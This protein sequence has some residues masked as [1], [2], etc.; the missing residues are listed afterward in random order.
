MRGGVAEK[1]EKRQCERTRLD[2]AGSAH[3]GRD[4]EAGLGLVQDE[5]TRASLLLKPPEE[6]CLLT[7]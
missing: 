6:S 4:L 3:W 1:L 7:P 5:Q 2:V